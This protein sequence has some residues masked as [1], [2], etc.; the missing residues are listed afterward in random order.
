MMG[1]EKACLALASL[2]GAG[3]VAN[4]L[5][6]LALPTAWYFAVPGVTTTGPFNQHF[7][8]DIGLI[9]S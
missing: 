9:S 7:L 1:A 3:S 5:Y 2:L 4:G 6:M 8:R